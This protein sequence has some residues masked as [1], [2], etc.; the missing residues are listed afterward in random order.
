MGQ[1]Q[2]AVTYFQK[3]NRQ[4]RMVYFI[5]RYCC[6]CPTFVLLR[7]LSCYVLIHE[8]SSFLLTHSW[9]NLSY[10]F[11]SHFSLGR[12]LFNCQKCLAESTTSF[13]TTQWRRHCDQMM[14]YKVVQFFIYRRKSSHKLLTY[15][16]TFL[17]ITQKVNGY[18][19]HL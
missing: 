18:F 13:M 3:T 7:G 19:G 16:I 12:L 5:K 11:R 2:K 4:L 9:K 6:P 15:I 10:F 17:K 1:W 8:K 14:E